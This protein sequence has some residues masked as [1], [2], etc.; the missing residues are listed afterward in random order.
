MM[1]TDPGAKL[2]L[3]YDMNTN[4]PNAYYRFVMGQYIPKMQEMGLEISEAWHTAYGNFPNRL[5]GFVCHNT[6]TVLDLLENDRWLDLNQELEKY[7]TNF[8]YKVIH[9]REGFQF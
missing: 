5:I 6:Q 3:S 7:V 8:T 9:Y 1:R 2:L 4:D